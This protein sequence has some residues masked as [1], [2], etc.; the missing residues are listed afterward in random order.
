M[1]GD[2][3]V[4]G[5]EAA[6]GRRSHGSWSWSSHMVAE[7]GGGGV[8]ERDGGVSVAGLSTGVPGR[9]EMGCD[10]GGVGIVLC[11]MGGEVECEWREGTESTEGTGER[12]LRH[13]GG[14]WAGRGVIAGAGGCCTKTG[15]RGCTGGHEGVASGTGEGRGGTGSEGGGGSEGSGTG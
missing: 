13:G 10:G 1:A 3:A 9:G 11:V 8:R 14:V 4:A 12:E 2:E 6:K 5:D 7:K 15:V